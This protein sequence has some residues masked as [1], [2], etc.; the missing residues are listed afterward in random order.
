MDCDGKEA[1]NINSSVCFIFGTKQE[2]VLESDTE[3]TEHSLVRPLRIEKCFN[4]FSFFKVLALTET[5]IFLKTY[6]Q[7]YKYFVRDFKYVT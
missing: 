2:H 1:R 5:R 7:K 3:R 6:I 4:F